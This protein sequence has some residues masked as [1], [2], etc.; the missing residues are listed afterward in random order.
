MESEKEFKDELKATLPLYKIAGGIIL[1][2]LILGIIVALVTEKKAPAPQPIAA[3]ITPPPVQE[4]ITVNLTDTNL[5][6]MPVTNVTNATINVAQNLTNV[7]SDMPN[8][9][10]TPPPAV[11]NYTWEAITITFPNTLK[12]ITHTVTT[13]HYIDIKEADGTPV[14]NGEQF[15]LLINFKDNFGRNTELKPS[16]ENSKWLISTLIP[17]PGNYTL[18]VTLKCAE[19]KGHCQR[20]YDE[21]GSTAKS[22]DFEV[23]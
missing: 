12:R 4:N 8:L 9:T 3:K 21:T 5:T 14:T 2:L 19:K 10:V 20:L 15:A 7:T 23:I 18:I 16:F 11:Y 6:I 1:F 17:N 22:F 13:H